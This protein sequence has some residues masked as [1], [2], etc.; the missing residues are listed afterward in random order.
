MSQSC[1]FL[2]LL[3]GST[4]ACSLL[5]H[6]LC[7]R[8]SSSSWCLHVC[9]PLNLIQVG[10]ESWH[11]LSIVYLVVEHRSMFVSNDLEIWV[12]VA[13]LWVMS[14][15]GGGLGDAVSDFHLHF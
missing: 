5:E 11:L 13:E 6:V 10:L 9:L 2:V 15:H 7:F 3:C 12:P 14:D 4:V 8:E 1:E